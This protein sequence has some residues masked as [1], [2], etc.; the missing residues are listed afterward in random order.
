M[1]MPHIQLKIEMRMIVFNL[2]T[3]EQS[4][5]KPFTVLEDQ[6]VR[7]S[8]SADDS[9]VGILIAWCPN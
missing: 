3:T 7:L 6:I 9:V 1:N 2:L 8:S 4:R 5:T